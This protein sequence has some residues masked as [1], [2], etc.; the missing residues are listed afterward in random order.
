M[1]TGSGSGVRGHYICPIIRILR[2]CLRTFYRS[3]AGKI[4]S[5][6]WVY[7]INKIKR[8]SWAVELKQSTAQSRR[9]LCGVSA[10]QKMN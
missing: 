10:S 4:H 8:V 2:E 6:E 5:R 9:G 3:Q 7:K 1:M